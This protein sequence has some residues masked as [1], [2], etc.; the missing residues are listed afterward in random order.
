MNE[1]TSTLSLQIKIDAT[2]VIDVNKTTLV[3]DQLTRN[4]PR[5]ID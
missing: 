2:E 4:L 5:E 3:V 1:Q